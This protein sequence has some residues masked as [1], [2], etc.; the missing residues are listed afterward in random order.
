M[1]YQLFQQKKIMMKRKVR[2]GEIDRANLTLRPKS[3]K[4]RFG[5][6]SK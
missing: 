6:L 1:Y 2:Q 4:G 5:R 3:A